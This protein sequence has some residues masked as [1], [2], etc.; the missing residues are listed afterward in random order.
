M[1]KQSYTNF[2]WSSANAH[3]VH[4]PFVFGFISKCFYSKTPKLTK[5]EYKSLNTPIDYTTAELLFRIINCSRSAK[6]FVL[7]KDA[8]P[9]TEM[10]RKLGEMHNLQLWFFSPL[11]PIPGGA[12]LAY[13]SGA[14][15]SDILPLFEEIIPNIYNDKVCI[16]GNI[17]ATPQTEAAWEAI[18]NDPRVTVTID[19]Y[20]L[21]LVFF[22]RGQAGQHFAIRAN[23][24]VLTDA[25]LGIKN[26]WGLLG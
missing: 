1:Q 21:G 11:A 14:G 17:H 24:S 8:A 19:T 13:I 26:L 10:L 18:K 2:L 4:S 23:T 20:H 12:D 15:K 3:G 25:F 6:L 16:I 9:V 22:R 5:K 7:G